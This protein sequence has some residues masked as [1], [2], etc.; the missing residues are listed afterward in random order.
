MNSKL[1]KNIVIDP[2]ILGG[3]PVIAGTRIPVERVKEL[4][5]QGYTP[6]SLKK[7]YPQ[8]SMKKIQEIIA[9]LMEIGLDDFKKAYKAQ[10]ALG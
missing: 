6:D 9:S 7:E 10:P 5:R 8:V 3:T 4:V 2:D 1:T